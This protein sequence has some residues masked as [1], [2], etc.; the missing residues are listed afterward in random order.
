LPDPGTIPFE[1]STPIAFKDFKSRTLKALPMVKLPLTLE[2]AAS[3]I[4]VAAYPMGSFEMPN[5]FNA[6][7]MLVG[8]LPDTST[9]YGIVWKGY[10]PDPRSYTTPSKQSIAYL[11][12]FTKAGKMISNTQV[13]L[14]SHPE[15]P[16]DCGNYKSE[17]R[18]VI[19]SDFTFESTH[20]SSY[21]CEGEAQPRMTTEKLVGNVEH[22]GT[23][24]VHRTNGEA[25][26][27]GQ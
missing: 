22:N 20:I 21:K 12:T 17:V 14:E 9:Y 4:K 10:L 6:E 2:Q 25:A 7:R 3:K 19:Q 16:S 15:G 5:G 18:S 27:G 8:M 24:V 23:V 13:Q 11:T 1:K 26:K